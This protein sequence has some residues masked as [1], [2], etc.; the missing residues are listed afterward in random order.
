MAFPRGEVYAAFCTAGSIRPCKEEPCAS[1]P[2]KSSSLP[3]IS[4]SRTASA[5]CAMCSGCRIWPS[6]TPLSR[7][8]AWTAT[9]RK[10]TAGSSASIPSPTNA[11]PLPEMSS[12]PPP[13]WP[14]LPPARACAA[15]CSGAPQRPGR[16]GHGLGLYRHGDRPAFPPARFPAI[17]LRGRGRRQ[18]SFAAPA[19]LAVTKDKS[20]CF[21]YI[22]PAL[23]SMTERDRPL[24]VEPRKKTGDHLRPFPVGR[25]QKREADGSPSLCDGGW[26]HTAAVNPWAAAM[27]QLKSAS[28]QARLLSMP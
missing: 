24:H 13:G 9:K 16:S 19:G 7:A 8:G 18:G 20:A 1:S 28:A 5:T 23:L 27:P 21:Q 3:S 11:L 26:L 15:I 4:T 10:G 2:R 6:T 25:P 22:S 14:S 12:P 17:G